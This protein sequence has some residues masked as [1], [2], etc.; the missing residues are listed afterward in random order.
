[1]VTLKS[2][3]TRHSVLK[4]DLDRYLREV[5][6]GVGEANVQNG[7]NLVVAEVEIVPDDYP[8]EG[9][10]KYVAFKIAENAIR[11]SDQ[12]GDAPESSFGRPGDL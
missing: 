1:M 11:V 12:Q 10:V 2:P 8:T 4:L 3:A 7:G 6:D 9:Q 5:L